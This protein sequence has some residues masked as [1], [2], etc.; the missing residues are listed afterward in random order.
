MKA[1]ASAITSA[2]SAKSCSIIWHIFFG[3]ELEQANNSPAK[4]SKRAC[5]AAATGFCR[6]SESP[7]SFGASGSAVIESISVLL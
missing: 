4:A 5:F 2:L 1:F 3:D 7:E 6:R